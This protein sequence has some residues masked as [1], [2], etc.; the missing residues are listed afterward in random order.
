MVST[1]G[2]P[3]LRDNLLAIFGTKVVSMLEPVDA[4]REGFTITGFVSSAIK[5]GSKTNADRQ[6]FCLNGRPV[7]LPK[8]LRVVNDVYRCVPTLALHKLDCTH[9]PCEDPA[10]LA[11]RGYKIICVRWHARNLDQYAGACQARLQAAA[12]QCSCSTS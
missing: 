8:A 4:C 1:H 7:S 11:L 10:G 6:F 2:K 12:R 3:T 9:P 5:S